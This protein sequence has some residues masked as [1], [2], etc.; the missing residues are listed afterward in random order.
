M[1]VS[2]FVAVSQLRLII[3]KRHK[4]NPTL[5]SLKANFAMPEKRTK[6]FYGNFYNI[7]HA[8]KTQAKLGVTTTREH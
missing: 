6:L 3:W 2:I 1:L 5:S 8:N 7:G 4:L